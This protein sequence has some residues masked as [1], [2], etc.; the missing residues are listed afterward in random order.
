M[1]TFVGGTRD[2]DA[3]DRSDDQLVAQSLDAIRPVLNI[4]G[5]PILT[6]VYRFRRA[7][8]QH[9]VG[10]LE[11]MAL[12]NQRLDAHPGLFVT[13]SGFRGVG[14]PD[15]IADARATAVQV[16]AQLGGLT[17]EAAAVTTPSNFDDRRAR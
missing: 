7:S 4:K 9:E 2:P 1:R 3:L 17:S 10:H 12:I 14:I 16:A 8:A 6:R 13:G 5:D 15:C 11:R